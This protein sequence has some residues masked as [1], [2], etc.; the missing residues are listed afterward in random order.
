MHV[1]DTDILKPVVIALAA[2]WLTLKIPFGDVRT[3]V[4]YLAEASPGI[5]LVA[6]LAV[7]VIALVTVSYHAFKAAMRN[8]VEVLRYE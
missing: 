8:P 3:L 5:M 6:V 2:A 1:F 7:V 4:P